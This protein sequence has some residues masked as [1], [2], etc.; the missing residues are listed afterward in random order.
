MNHF[1]FFGIPMSFI[2]DDATIRTRYLQNSR[3]YHP[4]FHTLADEEARSEALEL[5]TR[6]N[7]AFK[8][9]SDPDAR[10]RYILQEKGVLGAEGEQGS[11]PQDFLLD[12]MDINESV[13]EL[14]FDFNQQLYQNALNSL[15]KMENE[16]ETAIQ[17]VLKN[18]TEQQSGDQDLI[19]VRDFFYKKRY[20]LRTKEN[21]SKFAPA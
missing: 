12:M 13:M 16:L 5:S 3:K 8:I 9:L 7:E 2:V 14:E 4:D 11:L 20:L 18:W 10:M 15:Q 21:L 6:N 19:R 1:D 17:P